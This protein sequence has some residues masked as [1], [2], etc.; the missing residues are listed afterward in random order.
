MRDHR[1]TKLSHSD[2]IHR[3]NP[4]FGTTANEEVSGA[5]YQGYPDS[6]AVRCQQIVLHQYGIDV[7]QE[8]LMMEAEQ[9]GWYR[10]GHGSSPVH[11]GDLLSAHGVPIEKYDHANV[12]NLTAELAQGHK[13]IISVNSGELWQ[14][15]DLIKGLVDRLGF[16][17]ADHAVIVS[18]IDT[19]DPDHVKVVVTDPGTGDVAKEYPIESFIQAWK[20]S[21]FSMIATQTPAPLEFNPG[22]VHFDY[23]AGHIPTIGHLSYDDFHREFGACTD[24]K[25]G[26][27]IF[28]DQ[29]EHL[30]SAVHHGG[31]TQHELNHP[32]DVHDIFNTSHHDQVDLPHIWDDDHGQLGSLRHDQYVDSHHDQWHDDPGGAD[33]HDTNAGIH[34]DHFGFDQHGE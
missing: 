24:L 34:D 29:A 7:P 10:P 26:T 13:V 25:A 14:K 4:V 2:V 20:D 9:H 30:H 1:D 33:N 17:A 23:A 19:T 5:V 12:F 8:K 15:N 27:S 16:G 3:A 11:V 31:P 22:M 28:H 6:C 21:G 32:V 18:G